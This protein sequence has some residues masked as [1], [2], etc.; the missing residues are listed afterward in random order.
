MFSQA[1]EG[2]LGRA[3]PLSSVA[4]ARFHCLPYLNA[5]HREGL[6]ARRAG[7][8]A[9]TGLPKGGPSEIHPQHLGLAVLLPGPAGVVGHVELVAVPADQ[10]LVVQRRG[11]A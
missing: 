11:V 1:C 6:T 7:P 4:G 10:R 3:T 2:L 9:S 5:T 8:R